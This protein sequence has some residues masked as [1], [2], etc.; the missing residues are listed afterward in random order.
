MC[1]LIYDDISYCVLN[2]DMGKID[3]YDKIVIENQ[4]KK[5]IWNQINFYINDGLGIEFIAC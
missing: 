2:S 4:K 5:K 1:D 3:V